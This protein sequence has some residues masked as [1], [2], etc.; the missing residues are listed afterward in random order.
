V[1]TE[2]YTRGILADAAEHG[3]FR[4]NYC[5]CAVLGLDLEKH[6]AWH[7]IAAGVHEED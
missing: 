1:S 4:C 6:N 3:V 5:G 7:D 2:R